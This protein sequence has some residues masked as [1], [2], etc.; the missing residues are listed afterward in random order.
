MRI[1]LEVSARSEN[2][3]G[4]GECVLLR[5]GG[6]NLVL[7]QRR[8]SARELYCNVF[9]LNHKKTESPDVQLIPFF[10]PHGQ[11]VTQVVKQRGRHQFRMPVSR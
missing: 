8:G 6:W 9:F 3:Y 7:Y 1:V 5:A 11:H 10:L 4:R 2:E